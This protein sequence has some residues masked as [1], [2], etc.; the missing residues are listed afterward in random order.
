MHDGKREHID[1]IA[2][3]GRLHQQHPLRTPKPGALQQRNAFF[4]GGQRHHLHFI[5][6]Q[7]AAD[8]PGMPGIR[9]QSHLRDVVG[10]EQR[11]D[12]IRPFGRGVGRLVN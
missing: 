11:I 7:A 4:F 10:L 3:A 9:H 1:A 12:L 6:G 8:Q 5:I 2:N